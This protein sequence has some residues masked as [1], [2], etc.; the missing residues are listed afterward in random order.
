[1]LPVDVDAHRKGDLVKKKMRAAQVQAEVEL[2]M[3]REESANNQAEEPVD[4]YWAAL[5]QQVEQQSSMR[6]GQDVA[7]DFVVMEDDEELLPDDDSIFENLVNDS[8]DVSSD[9]IVDDSFSS[10]LNESLP[11]TPKHKST[12]RKATKPSAPAQPAPLSQPEDVPGPSSPRRSSRLALLSGSSSPARPSRAAARSASPCPPPAPQASAKNKSDKSCASTSKKGKELSTKA[13]IKCP[14]CPSTLANEKTYAVH[15]KMHSLKRSLTK[16][17]KRDDIFEQLPNL[18]TDTMER[19]L[20]DPSIGEFSVKVKD[21]ATC[22]RNSLRCYEE[23]HEELFKFLADNLYPLI[24]NAQAVFSS[25]LSSVIYIGV[26]KLLNC[27][28]FMKSFSKHIIGLL[29]EQFEVTCEIIN[30]FVGSCMFELSKLFIIYIT[31]KIH[32]STANDEVR[33]KRSTDKIDSST[34][35]QLCYH[36]GGSVVKGYLYKGSKYMVTSSR[37]AA[38]VSVLKNNFVKSEAIGNVCADN[39]TEF[40]REKDRG[41]LTHISQEA[42]DWF[43]VLFDLLMSL[44]GNDGSLPENVISENVLGDSTILCL[45]D[46][47]VGSD[48]DE[49][50]SLDFLMQMADSCKLI[51]MKGIMSRRLNDTFKKAYDSMALRSRLAEHH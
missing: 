35:L 21:V 30:F 28:E 19:L 5:D 41:G 34:F 44:E 9:A 14:E 10:I 29:D 36:I 50:S 4:D 20:K 45:W 46:V 17:A 8:L 24:S 31:K 1:M 48:L 6:S 32:G 25:S 38:F 7:G 40:T 51:V 13:R 2:N 15:K 11:V 3:R 22:V 47:L 43:V 49:D 37:W 33:R 39:V 18:L 26:N 12:P 27:S 42:L 16:A 23:C